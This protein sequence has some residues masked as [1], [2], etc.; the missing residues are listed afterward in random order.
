M[1]HVGWLSAFR[2]I[3][4]A[5]CSLKAATQYNNCPRQHV[6][7]DLPELVEALPGIEIID[8]SSVNAFDDARVACAIIATR[9][10]KQ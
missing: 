4:F 1:G 10:K 2:Q 3:A 6:G 9:R 5:F 7:T 8:R